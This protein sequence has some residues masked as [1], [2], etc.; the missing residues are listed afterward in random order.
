M[1]H[2]GQPG[3]LVRWDVCLSRGE[4]PAAA[5]CR[6]REVIRRFHG[7]RFRSTSAALSD[8]GVSLDI[9]SI[10]DT[11]GGRQSAGGGANVHLR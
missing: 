4:L 11:L 3:G 1:A 6:A 5:A 7:P 10:G 2:I 8:T 9:T